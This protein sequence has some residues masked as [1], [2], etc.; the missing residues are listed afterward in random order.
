[1]E[2]D[3]TVVVVNSTGCEATAILL[4]VA[5]GAV[6]FFSMATSFSGASLAADGIGKDVAMHVGSGYAPDHGAY[7]LELARRSEPLRAALGLTEQPR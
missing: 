1:V 6:M 3:L 7:A 2:A 4:T 5:G